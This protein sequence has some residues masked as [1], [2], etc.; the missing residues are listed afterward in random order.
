MN[1][2][3]L[4]ALSDHLKKHMTTPDCYKCAGMEKNPTPR[5]NYHV[6]EYTKGRAK[7]TNKDPTH[8][9]KSGASSDH[10]RSS[11]VVTKLSA[12]TGPITRNMYRNAHD[13]ISATPSYQENEH[14]QGHLPFFVFKATTFLMLRTSVF[15]HVQENGTVN[16]DAADTRGKLGVGFTTKSL[17]DMVFTPTCPGFQEFDK[18]MRNNYKKLLD[19]SK[20]KLQ[21]AGGN[22]DPDA[23]TKALAAFWTEAWALAKNLKTFHTSSDQ[24]NKDLLKTQIYENNAKTARILHMN[25]ASDYSE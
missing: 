5:H 21:Y 19:Q 7:H 2:N 6:D 17:F 14:D 22:T 23:R 20:V 3:P 15:G 8:T 12:D 25:S 13:D 4:D 1:D 24:A 16:Y 10:K 9:S 11:S 18:L